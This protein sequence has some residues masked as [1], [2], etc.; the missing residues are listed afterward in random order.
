MLEEKIENLFAAVYP[1]IMGEMEAVSQLPGGVEVQDALSLLPGMRLEEAA[2]QAR[3]E[4]AMKFDI[5]EEDDALVHMVER[6]DALMSYLCRESF[7]YGYKIGLAEG[8]A[9][10]ESN[11]M[12]TL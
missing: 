9:H 10:S 11:K 3:I 8:D 7:R 6:Y 12:D 5:S 4:A 2:Y 1:E